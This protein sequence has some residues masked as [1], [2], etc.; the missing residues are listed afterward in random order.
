M[1]LK[2][3]DRISWL[4]RKTKSPKNTFIFPSITGMA[5]ISIALFSLVSGM[6]YA[7]NLVLI[8]GLLIFI[9][10]GFSSIVTNFH[11]DAFPQIEVKFHDFHEDENPMMSLVNKED[12]EFESLAIKCF[13]T[14]SRL[15]FLPAQRNYQNHLIFRSD[16]KLKRGKYNIQYIEFSTSYPLGLFK[17]WRIF[18]P[19]ET[20]HVYPKKILE[21][22]YRYAK[23]NIDNK[24]TMS[25]GVDEYNGHF[26]GAPHQLSNRTD[27]KKFFSLN[28][29]WNKQ[30]K[31]NLID[32]YEIN[33]NS[34]SSN[35]E[36]T[37][38][39]LQKICGEIYQLHQQNVEWK[40]IVK[41]RAIESNLKDSL[42]ELAKW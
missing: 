32:K 37:E 15:D 3:D 4:T 24:N 21:S 26:K 23:L 18:R 39:E 12:V 33:L 8:L 29:V 42:K 11:L 27:W 2:W 28:Q 17:A 38:I 6:I 5:L 13:F 34:L 36:T 20:I 31:S 7:N 25:K 41:N 9:L 10:V 1:K 30:F 16:Q 19:N 35:A 22:Q 14:E 40:L